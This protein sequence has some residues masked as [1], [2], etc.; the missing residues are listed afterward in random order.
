MLGLA[1]GLLIA[2]S[3]LFWH[4]LHGGFRLGAG[5]T[6]QPTAGAVHS[7]ASAEKTENPMPEVTPTANQNADQSIDVEKDRNSQWEENQMK[8]SEEDQGSQQGEDHTEK[9]KEKQGSQQEE[10]QTKKPNGEQNSKAKVQQT[11]EPTSKPKTGQTSKSKAKQTP[12]PKTKQTPKPDTKE[13]TPSLR[14]QEDDHV[15]GSLE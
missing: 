14:L 10:K 3:V 7:G 5:A 4:V 13:K 2:L 1:G 6:S 12:K 8:K 11:A 9:P 15:A